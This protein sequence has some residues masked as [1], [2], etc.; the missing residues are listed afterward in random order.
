[1]SFYREIFSFYREFL[2]ENDKENERK[3]GCFPT[4]FERQKCNVL[5]I[6]CL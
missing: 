3:R 4:V 2:G 5:I 6:K 1:M